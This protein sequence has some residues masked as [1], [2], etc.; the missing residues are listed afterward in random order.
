M[1]T[2]SIIVPCYNVENYLPATIRS[3]VAQTYQ[4]WECIIVDDGSS[5]STP[6][7]ARELTSTDRRISVVEQANAGPSAARITGFR[8]AHPESKF[9]LW[10]DADDLLEPDMLATLVAYLEEYPSVVFV[11]CN[12][13]HIDVESRP[14]MLGWEPYRLAP[15]KIWPRRIPAADPVTPFHT[16]FVQDAVCNPSSSL[17]RRS[18]YEQTSGW[19][20][21]FGPAGEDWDLFFRLAL[22]GDSHYIGQRL[23]RYRVGRVGQLTSNSSGAHS[24]YVKLYEQWSRF[25][26]V[27]KEKR[28]IVSDAV[29]F[30]EGQVLP[31]QW[32]QWGTKALRDRQPRAAAR[33]F[34]LLV[35]DVARFILRS[36]T[37]A[38]RPPH[39][40][41]VD[42]AA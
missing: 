17:I 23:V 42:L 11:F 10:L 30:R 20:P 13:Q 32:A 36:V 4:D 34:A 37:G 16:L 40:V 27:P 7:V 21:D 9:L 31:W 5:D 33:C 12:R 8:A 24:G 18:A 26:G 25:K 28:A 35:R 22:L 2:V 14:V 38:Y 15:G 1:P 19:D 29:R 6:A 41:N 3:V 39:V